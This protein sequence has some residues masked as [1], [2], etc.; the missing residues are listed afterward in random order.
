MF[1]TQL[2]NSDLK[3]EKAFRNVERGWS[4][5]VKDKLISILENSDFDGD[6]TNL[7]EKLPN[8]SLDT[9]RHLMNHYEEKREK[10]KGEVKE[11]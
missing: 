4:S 9:L 11:G 7:A 5:E 3:V 2:K 8:R 1:F 10:S 6:F